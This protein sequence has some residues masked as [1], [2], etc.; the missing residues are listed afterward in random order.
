M[1]KHLLS[2]LAKSFINRS[3]SCKPP[4]ALKR[5]LADTGLC[6]LSHVELWMVVVSRALEGK[7]H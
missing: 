1:I 2:T 5:W 6:K 4:R 7:V 3:A